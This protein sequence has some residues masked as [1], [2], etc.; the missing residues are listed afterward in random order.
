M[1]LPGPP[2]TTTKRPLVMESRLIVR[3]SGPSRADLGGPV[4]AGVDGTPLLGPMMPADRTHRVELA[5]HGGAGAAPPADEAAASR[6]A[7]R[8][9]LT[10]ALGSGHGVLASGG[11][12]ADAVVV[13]VRVLEDCEWLNAGRGSALTLAGDVEMDAA[14][15]HARAGS[16]VTRIGISTMGS[17]ANWRRLCTA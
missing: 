3:A 11:S 16:Q 8:E 9:A 12:A 1:P 13:A 6:A 14:V 10:R 5:V 15:G 2:D 17:S 7:V 4:P